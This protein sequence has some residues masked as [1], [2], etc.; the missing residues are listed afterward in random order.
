V[1]QG[2]KLTDLPTIVA[3]DEEMALYDREQEAFYA[4]KVKT[5]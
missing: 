2:T 5:L 4:A 3:L 1:E